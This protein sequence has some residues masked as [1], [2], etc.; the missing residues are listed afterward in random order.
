MKKTLFFSILAM[1]ISFAAKAQTSFTVDNIMYTILLDEGETHT[2]LVGDYD[3]NSAWQGGVVN[4]IT[5]PATVDYNLTTYTVTAIADK[6]FSNFGYGSVLETVVFEEGNSITVIGVS[7]FSSNSNLESVNLEACTNLTTISE[8]AFLNAQSLTS[9]KIPENVVTIGAGAFSGCSA[10]GTVEFLGSSLKTIGEEAFYT[11]KFNEITLPSSIEEIGDKAFNASD[12]IVKSADGTTIKFKLICKAVTAPSLGSDVFINKDYSDITL[13]IPLCATGYDGWKDYF[14]DVTIDGFPDF[15]SVLGGVTIEKTYDGKPD[16]LIKYGAEYKTFSEYFTDPTALST[17]N[18][19]ITLTITGLKY[20]DANVEAEAVDEYNNPVDYNDPY[21]TSSVDHINFKDKPLKIIYSVSP[22]TGTTCNATN[23]EMRSAKNG[24]INPIKITLE[25]VKPYIKTKKLAEP[26]NYYAYA[27]KYVQNMY[28]PISDGVLNGSTTYLTY[29]NTTSEETVMYRVKAEFVDN[30]GYE[31]SMPSAASKIKITPYYDN[32]RLGFSYYPE[33]APTTFNYDFGF[34]EAYI[35]QD[36]SIIDATP[37]AVYEDGTLTFRCGDYTNESATTKFELNTG[38]NEPGWK[39]YASYITKVEFDES[40]ALAMPTSCYKWFNGCSSLSTIVGMENYLNVSSVTKMDYMFSGCSSIEVIDISGFQLSKK[41]TSMTYMFSGCSKLTTIL[42]GDGWRT[43]TGTNMFEGCTSIIGNDGYTYNS[44]CTDATYANTYYYFTKGKYKI[45]FDFDGDGSLSTDEKA[46]T[47]TYKD[48]TNEQTFDATYCTKPHGTYDFAYWAGTGITGTNTTTI[49]L[50]STDKGNRIY[51]VNWKLPYVEYNSSE[52]TLTFKYG[53]ESEKKASTNTTYELNKSGVNPSWSNLEYTQKVVFDPS[54]ADARPETC[55]SWFSGMASL[56]TI[57]GLQYL[58]TNEVKDMTKMFYHCVN[59]TSLNLSN[60][61]TAQVT[62]M[63]NM[64]NTCEN[65]KTIRVGGGWDTKKVTSEYGK[66]G[67]FTGC[68]NLVGESGTNYKTAKVSD[69]SYARVD[70]GPESSTP[71]YLTYSKYPVDDLIVGQGAKVKL[72]VLD[73]IAGLTGSSTTSG[74]GLTEVTAAGT[75]SYYLTTTDNVAVNNDETPSYTLTIKEGDAIVANINVIVKDYT[76]D[77]YHEG[78]YKADDV[79][80]AASNAAAPGYDVYAHVDW[81]GAIITNFDAVAK[82]TSDETINAGDPKWVA[83]VLQNTDGDILTKVIRCVRVDNIAPQKVEFIDPHNVITR[84]YPN[85]GWGNIFAEGTKL[86]IECQDSNIPDY[87]GQYV[88]GFGKFGY[89]F[90]ATA[91]FNDPDDDDVEWF[92]TKEALAQAVIDFGDLPDGQESMTKTLRYIAYDVAGNATNLEEVEFTITKPNFKVSYST[93]EDPLY[94]YHALDAFCIPSNAANGATITVT[95][96]HD[97]TDNSNFGS[98]SLKNYDDYGNSNRTVNFVFDLKGHTFKNTNM[99]YTFNVKD[100]SMTIYGEDGDPADATK[101]ITKLNAQFKIWFGTSESSMTIDGGNYTGDETSCVYFYNEDEDNNT[102]TANL[103][104]D[105]GTFQGINHGCWVAYDKA[106]VE[107]NDGTFTSYYYKN[108]ITSVTNCYGLRVSEGNVTVNGGT[109]KGLGA[110]I[111]NSTGSGIIS[112]GLSVIDNSVNPA[113][114]YTEQYKSNQ[115]A[116]ATDG[117]ALKN[118]TVGALFTATYTTSEN[119]T[120]TRNFS[121]LKD[122]LTE[123]NY[124]GASGD[125]TIT[126]N[127]PYTYAFPEGAT[128]ETLTLQTVNYVLNLD[129]ITCSDNHLVLD[130]KTNVTINSG[131]F[132]NVSMTVKDDAGNLTINDGTFTAKNLLANSSAYLL[133][134]E[135]GKVTVNDGTFTN[136]ITGG[137]F[138]FTFQVEG[139][140]SIIKGGTFSSTGIGLYLSPSGNGK[141]TVEGGTFENIMYLGGSLSLAPAENKQITISTAITGSDGVVGKL[142]GLSFFTTGNNGFFDASGNQIPEHYNASSYLVGNSN[143]PITTVYVK[144]VA[145]DNVKFKAEYKDGDNTITRGFSTLDAAIAEAYPQSAKVTITPTETTYDND[146]APLTFQTN[147]EF[148]LDLGGCT[149]SKAM[150]QVKTDNNVTFKSGIYNSGENNNYALDITGGKVAL[151]STTGKTT[152]FVGTKAAIHNEPA[153][154]LFDGLFGFYDDAASPQLIPE[155]YGGSESESITDKVLLGSNNTAVKTVTVGA[156]SAVCKVSYT[157]DDNGTATTFE[158]E[159]AS[160]N[161]ALEYIHGINENTTITLKMLADHTVSESTLYDGDIFA[162]YS[163]ASLDFDLG[164]KTLNLGGKT[165]NF[166]MN[167][168]YSGEGVTI[169]NGTLKSSAATVISADK[170]SSQSRK[171]PLTLDNATIQ[172]TYTTATSAG[173]A[174]KATNLTLN[175]GTV[176][177]TAD[178]TVMPYEY[179]TVDNWYYMRIEDNCE[180]VDAN[181]KVIP[182]ANQSNKTLP[183]FG[184]LSSDDYDCKTVTVQ[185]AEYFTA[186]ATYSDNSTVT[187]TFVSLANAL[188]EDSYK[189]D[190]GDYP[191]KVTITQTKETV[192]QFIYGY[193]YHE[194]NTISNSDFDITL[195]SISDTLCL[196]VSN[197]KK[198]KVA[199][200]DAKS[201]LVSYFNVTDGDLTITGGNYVF[202]YGGTFNNT[203]TGIIDFAGNGTLSITGGTFTGQKYMADEYILRQDSYIIKVTGGTVELSSAHITGTNGTIVNNLSGNPSLLPTNA[204]F[205]TAGATPTIIAEKY[206]TSTGQLED[207]SGSAVTAVQIKTENNFTAAYT[208][209]ENGEDKEVTKSFATLAGAID[210]TYPTGVESVTITLEENYVVSETNLSFDDGVQFTLDLKSKGKTMTM[211]NNSTGLKF[212]ITSG[213]LTINGDNTKT[214]LMA[215]FTVKGASLVIKGGHYVG[216]GENDCIVAEGSGS[217]EITDGII[218]GNGHECAYFFEYGTKG[219]ISGGTFTTACNGN[220]GAICAVE[221]ATYGLNGSAVLISG[222][223]FGV[224]GDCGVAAIKNQYMYDVPSVLKDGYSYYDDDDNVIEEHYYNNLLSNSL[225]QPYKFVTVRKLEQHTI[226]LPSDQ[227]SATDAAD[228]TNTSIT[229]AIYGTTLTLTYSGSKTVKEVKVYPMPK[230]ITIDTPETTTLTANGKLTLTAPISPTNIADED[231]VV[232]WTSSDTNVATVSEKGVVTAVAAGEATITA[233]TVNGKTATIVITVE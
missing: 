120:E 55:L 1:L 160:L 157:Y 205:Y 143:N 93:T 38:T 27:N 199:A 231:K 48:L 213:A 76:S 9:I 54:F 67:V 58:Y 124:T 152:K 180:M 135:K 164:G 44:S 74:I 215:N 49:T 53:M 88:S 36:V 94:F 14:D 57:E 97:Y 34:T 59:L 149:V 40:F 43:A 4:T 201:T 228:A 161:T 83:Y 73:N 61:N 203:Q 192:P 186:T 217:V 95:L 46:K 219:T 25:D 163:S 79:T 137:G 109:F 225:D 2:V 165:L 230:S 5:I 114:I 106:T 112:S 122:A 142:S 100:G 191:T 13:S 150:F 108:N 139:G 129:E 84:P 162:N 233:E 151:A 166:E 62:S 212:S 85:S 66:D 39:D 140:E 159:F 80:I 194:G 153:T 10:L 220:P 134:A 75:T 221:I 204:V 81:D 11:T 107:I 144:S 187:K 77:W 125:V 126:Q 42:Q 47:Y 8:N 33:A 183:N 185:R 133:Y 92:Y 110:A 82:L 136:T 102:G 99:K 172:T 179:S 37:Y 176:F 24:R 7:A 78:W 116:T 111:Y 195:N 26:G 6:A 182:H 16:V 148:T 89:S 189:N 218:D 222:G 178:N 113:A 196:K 154:T 18:G 226:T 72:A 158:K 209:T 3:G 177:K 90:V 132:D 35:D 45:F 63:N 117:T 28:V 52:Y 188:V 51:S 17:S 104:I 190:A 70:G 50:S 208:V 91:D 64:F 168:Y 171:V 200:D 68:N 86:T 216:D 71:G 223:T 146:N 169:H 173:Y 145:T 19:G 210:N 15:G 197:G 131:V 119:K 22:T 184:Y 23:N 206:N 29:T 174:V 69:V 229:T 214:T 193:N 87:D 41:I 224:S 127:L 31:P 147:V 232:T 21:S 96:L 198:V 138:V 12:P 65:L 105:G 56:T 170:A 202:C 211:P 98:W 128:E 118:V 60:F 32:Q 175:N 167:S 130:V 155:N 181:N 20:D 156:V 103:T 30:E 115:L 123:S 227:W 207:G 121:T 141:V 101:P